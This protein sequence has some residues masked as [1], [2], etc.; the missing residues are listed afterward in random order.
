MKKRLLIIEDDEQ[1][2]LLV[3]RFLR[4]KDWEF[5]DAA[6]G[7]EGLVKAAALRP[8]VVLLDVQLP[9]MEGWDICRK[10]RTGA[11]LSS[12][13][14]IMLSGK[15]LEPADKAKGLEAGADDFLAKPFDLTELMLRI[16]AILKGRGR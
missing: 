6:D 1:V 12:A 9:D 2:R 13:A 5:H 3:A 14:V 15:R 16:D 8:D 10:L 7:R 11:S 4:R